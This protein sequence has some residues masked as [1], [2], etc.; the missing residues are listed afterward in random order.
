MWCTPKSQE[1]REKK[2]HSEIYVSERQEKR[3]VIIRFTETFFLS[4]DRKR[5]FKREKEKGR[6]KARARENN[7]VSLQLLIRNEE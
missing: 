4:S 7:S 1:N 3:E 5:L 6:E 2:P